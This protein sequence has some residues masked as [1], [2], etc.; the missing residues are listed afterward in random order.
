MTRHDDAVE[1]PEAQVLHIPAD[2]PASADGGL[3]RQ[4]SGEE[5]RAVDG[6]G[7][8]GGCYRGREGNEREARR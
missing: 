6:R 2:L 1:N 8:E 4:L 3:R 5:E 7:Q